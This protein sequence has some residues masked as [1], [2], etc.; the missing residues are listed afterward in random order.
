MEKLIEELRTCAERLSRIADTLANA[1]VG[2]GAGNG[3]VE[4][5]KPAP[6]LEE[7]RTALAELSRSG[8]TAEVRE[9]IKRHGADRLSAFVGLSIM[10]YTEPNIFPNICLANP[11][12]VD[13]SRMHCRFDCAE[14]AAS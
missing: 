8:L 13:A 14:P 11:S 4:S 10:C 9:L 1:N 6:T 7:V 3:T 5:A 2:V 12:P